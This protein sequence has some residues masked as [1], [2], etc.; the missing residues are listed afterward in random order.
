MIDG[1][2]AHSGTVSDDVDFPRRD[3]PMWT[4]NCDHAIQNRGPMK[5]SAARTSAAAG[6]KLAPDG[7]GGMLHAVDTI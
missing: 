6:E 5:I 3:V 2:D 4:A 1:E 7:R